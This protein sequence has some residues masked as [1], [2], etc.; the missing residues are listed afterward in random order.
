[1]KDDARVLRRSHSDGIAGP[2]SAPP[3]LD[4]MVLEPVELS[5]ATPTYS[6]H[7]AFSYDTMATLH[8]APAKRES[9]IR[10]SFILFSM[11]RS[12]KC[13]QIKK[14]MKSMDIPAHDIR[15][16]LMNI[17]APRAYTNGA[18]RG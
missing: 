2:P 10:L 15:V 18:G 5:P 17:L 12:L 9:S 11:L 8:S 3:M 16:S 14:V 7:T 1:M 6:A 13:I 4:S